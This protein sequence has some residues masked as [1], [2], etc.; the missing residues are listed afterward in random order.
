[1]ARKIKQFGKVINDNPVAMEIYTKQREL[2]DQAA[3]LEKQEDEH[4]LIYVKME[5]MYSLGTV[6]DPWAGQGMRGYDYKYPS[7]EIRAKERAE[8]DAYY[9][10]NVKPLRQKIDE[11]KKQAWALEEPLCVAV[12]GYGTEEHRVRTR[13]AEAEKELAQQIA[14]IERLKNELAEIKNRG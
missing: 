5:G 10:A 11:L 13:L 2:L 14:Y 4:F 7:Q 9:A 1:M 12:C 6:P 3:D 8:R